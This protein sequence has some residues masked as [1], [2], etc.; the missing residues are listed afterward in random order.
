[1]GGRHLGGRRRLAAALALLA[2]VAVGHGSSAAPA[3]PTALTAP[4]AP[5][6]GAWT[7][8][9]PLSQQSHQQLSAMPDGTAYVMD[10]GSSAITL[11]HSSNFGVTW[12]PL[13]YL[14]GISTFAQAR[15]ASAKAGYL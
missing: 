5:G 12:D 15:F 7:V 2:T 3:A 13:T 14:P 1:M 8:S 9:L 10:V 4:G 11:W 6:S